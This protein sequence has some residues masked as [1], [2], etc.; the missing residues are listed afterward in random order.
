MRDSPILGLFAR[1]GYER[2]DTSRQCCD[3]RCNDN[4]GRGGCPRVPEIMPKPA[5]P[6]PRIPRQAPSAAQ[7]IATVLVVIACSILAAMG[8]VSFV[9]QVT[10]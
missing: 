2:H 8:L 10:S 7:G 3:G 6:A 1:E 4:Q 5:R 9:S